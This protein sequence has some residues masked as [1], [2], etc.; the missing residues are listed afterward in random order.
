M[1][2]SLSDYCEIISLRNQHSHGSICRQI[3]RFF[4]N[5]YV[6]VVMC[7]NSLHERQDTFFC[8]DLQL[9]KEELRKPV[10]A[11]GLKT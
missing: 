1:S 4:R 11:F 7:L 10:I 6:P 2:E 9:C 3:D 8:M 5:Y